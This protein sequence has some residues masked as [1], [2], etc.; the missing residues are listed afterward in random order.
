MTIPKKIIAALALIPFSPFLLVIGVIGI[1][2]ALL[3]VFIWA[4][5]TLFPAA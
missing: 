1:I 2:F 5:E 3:F 4:V